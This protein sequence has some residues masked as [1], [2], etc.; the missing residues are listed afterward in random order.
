MY[1]RYPDEVAIDPRDDLGQREFK[2]GRL[3]TVS[4]GWIG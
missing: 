1:S 3:V 2:N 4:L